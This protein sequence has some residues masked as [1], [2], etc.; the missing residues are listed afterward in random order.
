[1]KI[2]IITPS[3]NPIYLR[4][5]E[6]C[7][8]N[9]THKDWEWVILLNNGAIYTPSHKDDRIKIYYLK[10][11]ITSVGALKKRACHLATGEIIAEVD[12]D[13]LII[14]ECLYEVNKAFEED[15]E[16][17]FVYSET[18]Q[19]N[20]KFIPY[21]HHNGWTHGKYNWKGKD[22]IYMN[23][24][25]PYPANMGYIWFLPDHIRAWK[26]SIYIDIGGH[27]EELH[28]CDDHD[29]MCRLYLVT[30]FKE[31]PKPLYL[32]RVSGENTWLQRNEDIQNLT[33]KLYDKYIDQ[34]VD[35]YCEITNLPKI[36][37]CSSKHS[38]SDNKTSCPYYNIFLE[39]IE[40][41][42]S[43]SAGVVIANDVLQNYKDK[44]KIISEVHRIL[45]VGGLFMGDVPSTDGRGAFQDPNHVSYWNENSFWYYVNHRE[46]HKFLSKE[47]KHLLF[48][49]K[50][51]YTYF[52]SDWHKENNI[53]Y[54]KIHMDKI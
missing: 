32:Y 15:S 40:S 30:K 9:Q 26:K 23:N 1:M 37:L 38:I 21:N 24:L 13:D 41:I 54:V 47:Y 39:D 14:P 53:S 11:K 25:P 8:I 35:R 52:P 29:L 48:R 44:N 17:G 6:Q 34:M 43:N 31:V 46:Q 19:L 12:H 2:S 10:E 28:I 7:V 45:T 36:N 22:Y 20:E 4:E 27:N 33:V 51:L 3:H 50:R 16:V 18:V 42:K 5:L 49:E